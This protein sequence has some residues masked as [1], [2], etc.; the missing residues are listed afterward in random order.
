MRVHPDPRS[1]WE[2]ATR[3]RELPGVGNLPIGA[4]S[5]SGELAQNI[6]IKQLADVVDDRTTAYVPGR[7]TTAHCGSAMAKAGSNRSRL[8]GALADCVV[9]SQDIL[10]KQLAG[11]LAKR[12]RSAVAGRHGNRKPP[13]RSARTSSVEP[14]AAARGGGG[15][16]TFHILVRPVSL[17]QPISPDA[18][19]APSVDIRSCRR[20]R[21]RVTMPR[22]DVQ[23]TEA[24]AGSSE[25]QGPASRE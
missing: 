8:A 6:T 19:P 12:D 23:V 14:S 16:S 3:R 4:S 22:I 7:L 2:T 15:F 1:W 17:P 21:S 20:V 24:S 9:D 10:A 25:G 13:C 5:T 11:Y 18:R